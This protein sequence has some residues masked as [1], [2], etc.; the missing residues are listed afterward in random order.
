MYSVQCT[1]IITICVEK[2]QQKFTNRSPLLYVNCN[3]FSNQYIHIYP[4]KTTSLQIIGQTIHSWSL[5]NI[6]DE[7]SKR[8]KTDPLLLEYISE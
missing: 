1:L 3:S 4:C 2:I 6:S 5:I 8:M 7:V